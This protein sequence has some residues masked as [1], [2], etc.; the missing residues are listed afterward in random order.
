MSLTLK[1]TS[2]CFGALGRSLHS[3]IGRRPRLYR[4]R[5]RLLFAASSQSALLNK[6]CVPCES[7]RG[8]L[9]FMGLC[10]AMDRR[11]AESMVA[12]EVDLHF[13]KIY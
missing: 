6:K 10:E 12:K 2:I 7:D 1:S 3:V 11:Q 13:Q 8:S 9:G 4:G 5:E